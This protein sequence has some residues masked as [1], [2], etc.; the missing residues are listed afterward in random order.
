[1][2]CIGD[3]WLGEWKPDLELQTMDNVLEECEY[4]EPY[5]GMFDLPTYHQDLNG[6]YSAPDHVHLTI[7]D[8]NPSV[9]ADEV[10]DSM[11]K[12]DDSLWDDDMEKYLA[13]PERASDDGQD[14]LWSSEHL[15]QESSSIVDSVS[16]QEGIVSDS[17]VAAEK[18]SSCCCGGAETTK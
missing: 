15:R 13:Y 10:L 17:T 12:P 14:S 6:L 9:H 2:N 11:G 7:A 4:N 18:D 5:P 1:M 3:D 16:Q 8:F